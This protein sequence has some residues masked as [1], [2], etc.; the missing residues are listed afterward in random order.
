MILWIILLPLNMVISQLIN[1]KANK[2]T[3]DDKI[4]KKL[5]YKPFSRL[6]KEFLLGL[7]FKFLPPTPPPLPL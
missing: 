6:L 5:K 2:N 1:I 3:F 4:N 7:S